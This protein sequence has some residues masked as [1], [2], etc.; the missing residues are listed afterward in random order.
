[1]RVGG[2]LPLSTVDFPGCL[3]AVVFLRGCPW[4]CPYCHNPELQGFA[5]SSKPE[6][7]E[8]VEHLWR[9]RRTLDAVV[10]TGGEPCAQAGLRGAMEEVKQMGYRV[11]LHTAGAFPRRLREVIG[12]VDW[13]GLDVKGPPGEVFDRIA[14]RAGATRAFL[15]S[16]E[17]LRGAGVAFE[18]RTTQDKAVLRDE[19]LREL[20]EWLAE[21]GL[22]PTRVQPALPVRKE[23]LEWVGEAGGV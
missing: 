14:G 11:G 2:Y 16:L 22:P 21:R 5:G 12:L 8:V 1:M 20:Q 9:R 15:E 19:E 18:L 10:F 17:C 7:W 13:V 3:S 23:K 4:R 6:W